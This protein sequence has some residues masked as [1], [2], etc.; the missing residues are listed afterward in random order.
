MYNEV[1]HQCPTCKAKGNSS[2]GHGQVSQIGPGFGGYCLTDL[3]S[4]KHK[5][6]DNDLTAD[7][8]K[9]IAEC[10]TD[11]WFTCEYGGV[12]HHFQADPAALLAVVML[13][14]RFVVDRTDDTLSR[15]SAM[16]KELY[17]E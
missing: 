14:D 12:E 10:A 3:A 15:A 4:L 11:A 16:L 6:E 2:L 1:S 8:L 5:L 17:P 13:T 9:L 7:Q